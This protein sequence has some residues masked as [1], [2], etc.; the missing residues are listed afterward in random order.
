MKKPTSKVISEIN[1][2]SLVDVTLVLLIVFMITAPLMR[3]GKRLDLPQAEQRSSL[4]QK[5]IVLSLTSSR[6]LFL[7]GEMITRDSL[8]SKLSKLQTGSSVPVMIEGDHKVP[9]GEIVSVMDAVQKA[10]IENVSLVLDAVQS[11]K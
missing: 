11:K 10:G 3:S 9:Y 5:S 8:E 7:D 1:L 4:P 2:T 6:D